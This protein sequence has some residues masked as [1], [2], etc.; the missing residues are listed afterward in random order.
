[1][2]GEGV[3]NERVSQRW[4]QCFNTGEANTKDLSRSGRHKLWDIENIRRVLK[5]IRIKELVSCQKNLLHEKKS[6]TAIL[7]QL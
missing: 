7:R 5:K 1:M 3:V 4:F 2:E 6:Y